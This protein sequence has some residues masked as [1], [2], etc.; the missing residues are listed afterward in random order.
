MKDK[1]YPGNK[2]ENI[3]YQNCLDKG[4]FKP[5]QSGSPYTISLPPPNVTGS[6]HMG[7]AFQATLID[8]LIR[9][10]RMKGFSC[11]WQ[12]GIDH[13]GIA[14]QLVV[15]RSLAKTNQFKQDFSRDNFINEVWKWKNQSG[16]III[17]QL[18]QLL[19]TADWSR[20]CFTMDES[21]N[22][23]VLVAFKELYEDNL[24]YRGERLVNWDTSLQTAISDL[25]V[26]HQQELSWLYFINYPIIGSNKMVT[27]ATTRPETLFGDVALAF[28]PDDERYKHLQNTFVQLPLTN[29]Q[30]PIISDTS[31]D[32]IF[33]T[34]L[35][36]ITPAHDTND[37]EIGKRH[38]LP[39]NT[40]FNLDGTLKSNTHKAI[41]G[42]KILQARTIV[43]GLLEAE[44]L[45]EKKIEHTI[46]VPRGDRSGVIIEPMLTKQWYIDLTS[47][48]GKEKLVTPARN[49]I[50][51]SSISVIPKD[52][53][54][55]YLQWIDSIQDWCISRQIWWGHQIPIWYD[56]DGNHYCGTEEKEV[57]NKHGLHDSISLSKDPD[58]LDTWFSSALWPLATQGWPKSTP[59]L[60]RYPNT[61]LVTGFDIL[62]FWVI[63]MVLFGVYFGKTVPFKAIY[64]HGLVRDAQGNKMSKSKGNVIDPLDLVSGIS[65]EALV[66]KRSNSVIQDRQ[67]KIIRESTIKQFPNG[68]EGYGVDALRFSFA[69]MS[70][71]GRDIRFDLKRIE[72]YRNF[73]NKLFNAGKFIF[74][75]N[76]CQNTLSNDALF[77]NK[78]IRVVW[79]MG[80]FKNMLG[81]YHIAMDEYRFDNATNAMY[82]FVWDDYCNWYL[83]W[84][85]NDISNNIAIQQTTVALY[86]EILKCLSPI[87]PGITSYIWKEFNSSNSDCMMQSIKNPEQFSHDQSVEEFMEHIQRVIIQIRYL[88]EL[89]AIPPT[90]QTTITLYNTAEL[91]N[92]QLQK[93][94]SLLDS[95]LKNTKIQ[96]ISNI[97]EFSEV[98]KTIPMRIENTTCYLHYQ[99]TNQEIS[100][101]IQDI[102]RKTIISENTINKFN[103]MLNSE[104]FISKAPESVI[105]EYRENLIKEAEKVNAYNSILN[106]LKVN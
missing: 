10:H 7:H 54:S 75:Y 100:I 31:I 34:G 32:P 63:R 103:A 39:L 102:T 87:I 20:N 14:T 55:T 101:L 30:I 12:P 48:Y 2:F 41:A 81:Q 28:H 46:S 93:H 92:T 79:I 85:K 98:S 36:K 99:A 72:G 25:E 29:K 6:L 33:G 40:I 51:N 8:F 59:D 89:L 66:E 97:H 57:R 4:Y 49:A 70:N 90:N 5:T 62:F 13:A 94:R 37:F 19:V 22:H 3:D 60:S 73:C 84:V 18:K 11:L 68:I 43:V 56:K 26:I 78:D 77:N 52:W 82:H 47:Q 67:K 76:T 24:I 95:R 53:K 83:E 65:L 91:M 69:S 42:M 104:Q 38:S 74:P 105:T 64:M 17:D 9:F 21:Y 15:E 106:C 61:V 96:L 50:L 35:V 23:A 88:R 71:S 27:I 1:Y 44:N 80:K 86:H 58:V 16:N 45:V